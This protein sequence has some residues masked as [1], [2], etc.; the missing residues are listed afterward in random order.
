MSI[1][2]D[3]E[4]LEQRIQSI[5]AESGSYSSID[6]FVR[7][8]TDTILDALGSFSQGELGSIDLDEVID[9]AIKA[10][11]DFINVGMA[12]EIKGSIDDVLTRTTAFYQ[13]VGVELPGLKDAINRSEDIAEISKLFTSNLASMREELRDG[14]L[15]VMQSELAQGFFNRSDLEELIFQYA[16][17]KAHYARTNA[18]LVV[19]S[20]N[21]I[22]REQVRENADLQHGFYYGDARVNTRPFCLRCIGKVFTLQDIEQMDNG[23]LSPVKIY[24]GGWNCIHSWLWVDPEWDEE[25]KNKINTDPVVPLDDNNL[26]LKV[27]GE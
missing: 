14:T 7:T 20:Y 24:A 25:L 17:G 13:S 27:P 11:S 2:A 8:F 21:R 16:D 23:Q 26:Q 12:D 1:F 22:G 9:K 4:S 6:D 18:R 10:S 5:L 3:I 15:E 19:S